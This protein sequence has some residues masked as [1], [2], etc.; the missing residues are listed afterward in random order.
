MSKAILLSGGMDS[1]S[2]AFW[3]KPSLAVTVD[4]GQ[5]SATTEIRVSKIIT[6]IL[7]IEHHIIKVDC[8]SLGS[9][10]LI[11]QGSLDISPSPEWWPFRNQ[12]LITFALMKIIKYPIKELL[13][14]SVKSDGFHKD[15]TRDFYQKINQ[16]STCQE[17]N[18]SI[19]AP[20]ID[21]NTIELIR[22]SKIPKNILFWAHSCHKSNIACGNCRGCIKYK[23]VMRELLNEESIT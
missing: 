20:C 21:L 3:K 13:L 19:T 12:L 6:E 18:I 4:Y 8:K 23:N 16:V 14:A 11:G 17:G 22:L 7:K 1:I 9:G 10:D 2:L 15:G 5:L